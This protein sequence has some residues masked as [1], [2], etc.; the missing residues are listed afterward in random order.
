MGGKFFV[1]GGFDVGM[2]GE[3]VRFGGDEFG[4]DFVE[5]VGL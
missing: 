3:E 2:E 1:E 4:F 5:L